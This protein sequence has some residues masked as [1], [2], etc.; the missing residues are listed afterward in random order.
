MCPA[1]DQD[2]RGGRRGRQSY[3][4][5]TAA[6]LPRAQFSEAEMGEKLAET[7]ILI[8]TVIVLASYFGAHAIGVI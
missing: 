4:L 5:S 3:A 2:R 1:P 8:A 6:A 7:S